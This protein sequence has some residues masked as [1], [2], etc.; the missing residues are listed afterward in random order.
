M[1]IEDGK[2]NCSSAQS[3]VIQSAHELHIIEL[4]KIV[5]IV[6]RF[7]TISRAHLK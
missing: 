1:A 6:G 2:Q 7:K 4:G 5:F 3:D